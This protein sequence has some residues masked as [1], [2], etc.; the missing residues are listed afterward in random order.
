LKRGGDSSRNGAEL[1]KKEE[2]ILSRKRGEKDFYKTWSRGNGHHAELKNLRV[3]LAE[4]K[5]VGEVGWRN[6]AQGRKNRK[7]ER[8]EFR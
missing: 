3:G 1:P 7:G 6:G 4:N 5:K 8:G 2:K